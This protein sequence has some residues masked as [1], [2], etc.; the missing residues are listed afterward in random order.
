MGDTDDSEHTLTY[1]AWEFRCERVVY[2][3]MEAD[4]VAEM[5]VRRATDSA[6]AIRRIRVEVRELASELPPIERHRALC[7]VDGGGSIGA[8]AALYRGEPCGFALAHRGRWIE[9]TVRPRPA[10]GSDGG[11][12]GDDGGSPCSS[13]DVCRS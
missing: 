3:T 13:T 12:D 2:R 1:P 6:E 11:E 8:L 5:S 4:E 10:Y 7:W 9:W